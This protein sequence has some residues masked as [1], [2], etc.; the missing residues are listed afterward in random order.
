MENR[1][2]KRREIPYN[3]HAV[4]LIFLNDDLAL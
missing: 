1:L 3:T 4:N 2:A